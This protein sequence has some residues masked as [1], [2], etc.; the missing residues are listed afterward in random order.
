MNYQ[1]IP[2]DAIALIGASCRLPGIN[3]LDEFWSMIAEGKVVIKRFSPDEARKAGIAESIVGHTGFVSVGGVLED[4][5]KFDSGYFGTTPLQATTMDPQQRVFLECV[6]EAM[7]NAGYGTLCGPKVGVWAGSASIDYLLGHARD[8]LDHSSPNRYLQQWVGVD[9]DYLAAQTAYRFDFGGPAVT[10][11]TACSTSLVAVVQAIQSLLNFQCDFAIAGGVSIA[12]PQYRGYVYEEGSIMSADGQCLPFTSNSSGTVFGNGAGVVILRRLEEAIENGDSIIAVIRGGEINNDGAAKVGFTAPGGR[13]QKDVI[14]RTLAMSDV[15]P[16]SISYIETHGTGTSIGDEIELAALREALSTP[17]KTKEEACAQRCALGT[18]KANIGHTNAAAGI[19]GLIKASLVLQK[20]QIPVSI[21]SSNPMTTL[22]DDPKFYLPTETKP[23]KKKTRR[24]GISS[25][26][27]GGTNAH[28]ILEAAPQ[29]KPIAVQATLPLLFLSAH[30]KAALPE[31][32]RS[33]ATFL[34]NYPELSIEDVCMTS[35]LGRRHLEYRVAFPTHSREQLIDYLQEFSLG[36]NPQSIVT[37]KASSKPEVSFAFGK[38]T[39]LEKVLGLTKKWN[40]AGVKPM[41]VCGSENGV[42]AAAYAAGALS[43]E[44]AKLQLTKK[45]VTP[46]YLWVSVYSGMPIDTVEAVQEELAR[47]AL[48]EDG[49]VNDTITALE[50]TGASYILDFREKNSG[51]TDTVLLDPSSP[52][53]IAILWT[54]GVQ[55]DLSCYFLGGNRVPLPTYPFQRQ[56]HWMDFIP[57]SKK[58]GEDRFLGQRTNAP[59]LSANFFDAEWSTSSLPFLLDHIIYRKIVVSGA[60]LAVMIADAVRQVTGKQSCVLNDLRFPSALVIPQGGTK[61][62]QLQLTKNE[63]GFDAIVLTHES[64]DIHATARVNTEEKQSPTPISKTVEGE[65]ISAQVMDSWLR[66]RSVI[67]GPTFR[68]L[69]GIVVGSGEASCAM[70]TNPD[71]IN[72]Q[73]HPGILDS[74]LQLVAAAA[75][76][77]GNKAFVPT[78]IARLALYNRTGDGMRCHALASTGGATV[79]DKDKVIIEMEGL[80]SREV[81]RNELFQVGPLT[82]GYKISWQE[83]KKPEVSS[84]ST[85]QVFILRDKNQV[86]EELAVKLG[87]EGKIVK[88]EENSESIPFDIADLIIDCRGIDAKGACP[89]LTVYKQAIALFAEASKSEKTCQIA[90]ILAP[91]SPSSAPLQALSRAVGME[92]SHLQ[93]LA[94]HATNPQEIYL[95]LSYFGSETEI[96]IKGQAVTAPRF[97]EYPLPRRTDLVLS[98]DSTWL[99]TGGLGDLGLLVAEW[100]VSLGARNLVLTTRKEINNK[101]ILPDLH[102]NGVD[103][104]VLKADVSTETDIKHLIQ[105]IDKTLPPL[106]G[107]FH[108]AGIVEDHLVSDVSFSSLKETFSG[109]A[110][111]AWLL[112]DLTKHHPIEHFVMFS[113]AAAAFGAPGQSAYAMANAYLDALSSYRKSI[114]L[115]SLSIAWGPWKDIGM[116]ARTSATAKRR[117]AQLGIGQIETECGRAT[118]EVALATESSPYTVFLPVDWPRLIEQWPPHVPS[119]RFEKISK[120]QSSAEVTSSVSELMG[121]SADGRRQLLL[122]L[123]AQDASSVTGTPLTSID[124]ERSL[125]DYDLDSLL[126]TDLRVKLEKRFGRPI[127]AT[128]IFSNPTISALAEYLIKTFFPSN[129]SNV[130]TKKPVPSSTSN[131]GSRLSE[132]VGESQ[133]DILEMLSSKLDELQKEKTQ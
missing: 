132:S 103:I 61:H 93:T 9:K 127:S 12:L 56:K 38:T 60:A 40:T 66:K 11:Q 48:T 21:G 24:A 125:F 20:G 91:K 97:V 62:V 65:E 37:G 18:L 123:L 80:E 81:T 5:N 26:G 84:D 67:M 63:S 54:V 42:F 79:F 89:S 52:E 124:P 129:E 50:T 133:E 102:G 34:K 75:R 47:E 83:I 94:I 25:F 33:Y 113:S 70:S 100:L 104:R 101:P 115:A 98:G 74:V 131:T 85:N 111:G 86:A 77:E 117:L 110:V 99:I 109:K 49:V 105:E 87:Q 53:A 1:A 120:A 14:R 19:F 31:L 35:A 3:T 96:C 118:F 13:G 92:T 46:S 106:R 4:I 45:A 10:V 82:E 22:A 58:S 43:F 28:V 16:T 27:I 116:L 51:N 44:D 71:D 95:G 59:A 32:C 107:I 68:R 57:N 90:T 29:S 36:S 30:N 41:S 119:S 121:L 7:E 78:R 130:S 69:S 39:N 112:H 128:V 23:W 6:N 122:E 2:T 126:I 64:A 72:W 8:N 88:I 76:P 108:L 73:L 55:I 17:S 15:D 114:G